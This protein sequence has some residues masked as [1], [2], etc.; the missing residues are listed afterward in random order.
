MRVVKYNFNQLEGRLYLELSH[1]MYH[2]GVNPD[3]ETTWHIAFDHDQVVGFITTKADRYSREK[4]TC[5]WIKQFYSYYRVFKRIMITFNISRT[6]IIPS[7]NLSYRAK[8]MVNHWLNQH[9]L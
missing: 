1:H 9:F 3:F 5:I 4:I 2:Y 6:E 7:S 8:S